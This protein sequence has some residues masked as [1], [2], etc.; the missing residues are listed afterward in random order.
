MAG[1]RETGGRRSLWTFL[2]LALLVLAYVYLG[3]GTRDAGR[4]APVG[5]LAPGLVDVS[6]RVSRVLADD[7]Q[8]SRHQRFLV[9]LP[10][11]QRVLVAYNLNLAPRVPVAV[12]DEVELKG[13]FV[14]NAKGGV[15]HWTHRD[16]QGR[17]VGG[18]VMLHGHRYD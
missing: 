14:A 8:G 7:S 1:Q 11:G 6:G 10:T 17:H 4:A 13:E 5:T 3:G 2:A 9:D 16:P 15:I 18:F 12:G